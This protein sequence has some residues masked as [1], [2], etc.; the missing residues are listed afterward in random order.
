MI[1]I[2]SK[3][4]LTEITLE[5]SKNERYVINLIIKNVLTQY[6]AASRES[7][8]FI[9]LLMITYILLLTHKPFNSFIN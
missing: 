2:K 7:I 6:L 4:S 1:I 3:N 9:I 5:L 8:S